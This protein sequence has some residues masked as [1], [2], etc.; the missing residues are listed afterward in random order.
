MQ[1]LA[2]KNANHHVYTAKVWVRIMNDGSKIKLGVGAEMSKFFIYCFFP[3]GILYIFNRPDLQEHPLLGGKLLSDKVTTDGLLT[4]HSFIGILLEGLPRDR[5][6]MESFIE[7]YK[8]AKN[9]RKDN[10][11]NTQ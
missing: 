8:K 6:D 9:E 1:Q 3:V 7:K 4:V 10:Q 2:K 11:N 5:E